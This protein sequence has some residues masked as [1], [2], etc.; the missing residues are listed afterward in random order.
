MITLNKEGELETILNYTPFLLTRCSRDLRYL[1]VSKAYATM[2]GRAPDQ[3]AGK[4]IIEIMGPQG[5]ETIRPYVETVL[6]GQLVEYEAEIHFTDVGLRHL[7][8]NYVPDR[9]E[10]NQVIG[11][12]CLDH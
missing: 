12:I 6:R 9:D 7:H 10:Q 4:P 11:W 3:V 2:I 1:Y 5:F 8:V